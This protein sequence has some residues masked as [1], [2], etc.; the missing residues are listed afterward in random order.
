[1]KAILV[2]NTHAGAAQTAAH[3]T[4]EELRSAFAPLGVSLAVFEVNGAGVDDAVCNAIS[5]RPDAI[6]TGG[7]DGTISTAARHLADGDIPLGALPLGTL[8]H[9]A[10]DLGLPPAW[11]EAARVL[12]TAPTRRI[13]VAEVNGRI[14]V[15]NCSLGSYGE[16][17][18]RRDALRREHGHGKWRAMARASWQVFRTLRRFRFQ[19]DTPEG[20]STI[21]SP[22]AVVANNRYSGNVFDT[23]LRP[24]LD[25]GRLWIYAARVQTRWSLLRLVAQGLARSIDE[26]EGLDVRD[27]TAA[28]ITVARGPL[29]LACDGEAVN[30]VPPFRFRIRPRALPVLAPP[31][32]AS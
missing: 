31:P 12:A 14:F 3:P 23:S 5:R 8:N 24:R 32:A 27:S 30:L 22:F 19:I 25:A 16:A 7:G 15:N 10:R 29:P 11:R 9:F 1:M 18:R 2:L 13:D 26:A 4:A 17:V 6:L 20:H 21:R 28:T